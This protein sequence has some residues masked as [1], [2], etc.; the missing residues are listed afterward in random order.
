MS[1]DAVLGILFKFTGTFAQFTSGNNQLLN[2]LGAFKNIQDFGIARPFFQQFIFV[3]AHSGGQF[4]TL[5]GNFIP[6][7]AS[8]GFGN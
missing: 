6:D 5:Q 1:L 3:I 4:Y 8:F 7:T 2:L